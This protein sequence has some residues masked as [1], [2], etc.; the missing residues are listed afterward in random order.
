MR[1]RS[2][3]KDAGFAAVV[4]AA[5]Y[6]LHLL[7]ETGEKPRPPSTIDENATSRKA[8]AALLA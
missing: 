6:R 1:A 2:C 3:P 7:G 8:R 4:T 5:A